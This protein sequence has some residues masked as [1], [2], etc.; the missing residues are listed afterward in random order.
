VSPELR[1]SENTVTI[2]FGFIGFTPALGL[3]NRRPGTTGMGT[4]FPVQVDVG[5]AQPGGFTPA[6]TARRDQPPHD[7]EPVV[8]DEAEK[9]GGLLGGPYRD[10]RPFSGRLPC[11][12]AL[13]GPHQGVRAPR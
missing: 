9:G 13:G 11:L 4:P 10:R 6:Q 7:S 3:G 12:E 2:W 8:R 5:P 1:G